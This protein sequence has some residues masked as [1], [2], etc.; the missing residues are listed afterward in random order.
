[1]RFRSAFD[2]APIGLVM[3]ALDEGHLGSLRKVN[4]ALS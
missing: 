4:R 1:V 2:N 3:V